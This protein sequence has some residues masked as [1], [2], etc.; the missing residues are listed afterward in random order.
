MVVRKVL[1][2]VVCVLIVSIGSPVVSAATKN[3]TCV[4]GCV[5]AFG[6]CEL[7]AQM[8][9]AKGVDA[10]VVNASTDTPKG[11]SELLTAAGKA[12]PHPVTDAKACTQAVEAAGQCLQTCAEKLAT[13]TCESAFST[14]FKGC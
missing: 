9:E 12:C 2:W 4:R 14:C 1:P 8:T 10:C 5:A 6:Y 13:D 11:C 7:Q 3:P